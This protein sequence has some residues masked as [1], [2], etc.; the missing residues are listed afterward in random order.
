MGGRGRERI[1]LRATVLAP[2]RTTLAIRY[3][4][5]HQKGAIKRKLGSQVVNTALEPFE[6]QGKMDTGLRRDIRLEAQ[7]ISSPFSCHVP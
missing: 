4:Y 5:S 3:H 7:I 6:T 2:P 1:P